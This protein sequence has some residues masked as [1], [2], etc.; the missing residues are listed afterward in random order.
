[1]VITIIGILI[2]LLLPAVQAAR[3]A[4][5]MAQCQNNLKQIA[6]AALNHE[7]INR[8]F[9]TG[10]WGY[11]WAGDPDG[12]FG[13]LQPG[14]FFYNILPYMEQGILHDLEQGAP[15]EDAARITLATH[16]AETVVPSE[17]CPT[18]RQPMAL[19]M[20]TDSS[21]VQRVNISQTDPRGWF[22]QD[23]AAN[24]GSNFIPW[25]RGPYSW[26]PGWPTQDD[27]TNA[28]WWCD[29]SPTTI[30]NGITAQRSTVKMGEITD[31]TSNTYLAGEK[32]IC[33]DNYYD[34]GDPGDNDFMV[35][36]DDHDL[37]R[38]TGTNPQTPMPPYPDTPG[39]IY[40]SSFG[41]AHVVGFNMAFCDG[42]VHVMNYTI[43]PATHCYLGTRN[44][45]VAIDGNKF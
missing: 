24:A 30:T 13:K 12:G 9:P 7:Q 19:P 1:M 42:S 31:G 4:A 37:N 20:I 41:S 2:A 23:Y 44:D 6:L 32:N 25:L 26:P 40:W 43:D 14:G 35:S 10:G 39:V 28:A 22:R 11:Q 27:P 3:E 29:V 5:R 15:Q 45:G 34:G 17:T 16:M 21:I 33:T 18:R 8:W 38:W 36:A